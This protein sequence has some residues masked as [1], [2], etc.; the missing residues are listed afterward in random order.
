MSPLTRFL[1]PL[2]LLILSWPAAANNV[3]LRYVAGDHPVELLTGFSDQDHSIASLTPGESVQLLKLNKKEG[4]ARVQRESGEVGWVKEADLS[5]TPVSKETTSPALETSEPKTADQLQ[6][7]LGRLQSELI[8]MRA[9]SADILRTQAERD[10]LQSTVIS[11]KRELET[12]S[13]EKNALAEDQKQTWFLIGG[14][15]LLGGVLLGVLLPRIS[16]R[17]RNQWGSF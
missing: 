11:L 8:Q 15:I 10:Q 4:E 9:A 7:E 3:S 17:R 1:L 13:Q 14:L 5:E 12:L 2:T 6:Q 16:V